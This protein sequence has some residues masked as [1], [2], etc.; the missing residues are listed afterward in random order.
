SAIVTRFTNDVRQVQNTIFMALRIMARTPFMVIG[1]VIMALI[2]NVKIA[3][4]FL[5]TVPVLLFFLYFVLVKGSAMFKTVQQRVDRVN[6]TIQENI[7]GMRTIRSFVRSQ[8]ENNRFMKANKALAKDSAKAF[9]FVEASMPVL[10]FGMNIGLLFILWFGHSQVM[11]GSTNVG[12]V[13]TIINYAL[14]TVMAISM[15]TFIALAFSRAKA[16]IE[17]IDLVFNEPVDQ[18][19]GDFSNETAPELE[20]PITINGAIEFQN[21]SF[22]F[23][24]DAKET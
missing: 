15:F 5:I 21:V 23:D 22:Q 20:R 13:V 24:L 18:N 6:Q 12:D 2:V 7:A 14:R 17:R 8:F 19:E 3:S 16:S 10:L 1:S 11:A 4:I 9:R